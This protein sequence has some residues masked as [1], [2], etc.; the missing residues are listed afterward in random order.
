VKGGEA[1]W[2][3]NSD[4]QE[5]PGQAERLAQLEQQVAELSSEL[6][7]INDTWKPAYRVCRKPWTHAKP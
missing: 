4:L 1:V 7:G 5:I 2:I 6:E 3:A